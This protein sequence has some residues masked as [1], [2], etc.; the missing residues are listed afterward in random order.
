[1]KLLTLATLLAACGNSHHGTPD[2]PKEPV[3]AH[4]DAPP[5]VAIDAPPKAMAGMIEVSQGTSAGKAQS[6]AN[7]HFSTTLFG[8]PAGTDG[9][10]TLY[11]TASTQQNYSGGTISITGTA[12]AIT[13]TPTGTVPN[14]SYSPTATVPDPVFTAGATIAVSG[15]GGTDVGAFSGSVTA[16]ATLAG[17]TVP[18]TSISRSGYTATWT[19]GSGP[20]IWVIAAG[21]NMMSGVGDIIIC[22]VADNGSFTIPSTTFA[23]LPSS[24]DSAFAGVGRVASTT[25][26]AGAV[27]V[28]IDATSYITSGVLTLGP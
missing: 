5:D 15:A 8:T 16:P 13:L 22:K 25:V 17:Y 1:M 2:A 7:A 9:P 19:A 18:A 23:M 11:P 6:T 10:C 21:F 4:V 3:D 27:M 26:T 24:A 12:S 28:E 14:V 20:A